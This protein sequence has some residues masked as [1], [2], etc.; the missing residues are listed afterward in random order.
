M[1]H[2]AQE[3]VAASC[4]IDKVMPAFQ[5]AEAANEHLPRSSTT[6]TATS[7]RATATF[8]SIDPATG[9]ALGRDAG[10]HARPMST[11]PSKAAHRAFALRPVGRHDRNGA[12]QAP[13]R[14]GDLVAANAGRLG[15]A[16]DARHR[17]DHP[18]DPRPDR[19]MSPTT[20]ATY[21]GLA[22]KIEGAH[23]P[24]DKPDMEV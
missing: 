5:E 20:T 23:L 15:R 9:D 6:S 14:L 10:R 2:R 7:R 1:S 8:E 4:F 18:R 3:E 16:R 22:D 24:I 12:R 17:Q 13:V 21:G 19:A 11:A